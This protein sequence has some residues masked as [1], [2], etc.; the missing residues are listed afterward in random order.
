[1]SDESNEFRSLTAAPHPEGM[2][3]AVEFRLGSYA[4]VTAT[5]RATPAGVMFTG[6][7]A[8]E[9]SSRGRE[10]SPR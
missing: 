4:S 3:G 5:G 2:K 6:W 9:D 7:A 1:M 10:A 8:V